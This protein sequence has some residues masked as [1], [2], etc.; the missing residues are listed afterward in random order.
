MKQYID[1]LNHILE[2]GNYKQDRTGTGIY[3]VFGYQVLT[4]KRIPFINN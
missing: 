4:L 3:S 1:L 2:N